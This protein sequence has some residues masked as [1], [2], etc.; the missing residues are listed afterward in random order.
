MLNH[1]SGWPGKSEASLPGILLPFGRLVRQPI[2]LRLGNKLAGYGLAAA[3]GLAWLAAATP[4]G[5]G[6]TASVAEAC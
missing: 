3:T 5:R 6:S 4:G 2:M 1:N